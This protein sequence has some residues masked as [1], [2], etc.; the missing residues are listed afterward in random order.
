MAND[1]NSKVATSSLTTFAEI[2]NLVPKM[3][4]ANLSVLAN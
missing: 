2:V 1:P 3:V 4:E